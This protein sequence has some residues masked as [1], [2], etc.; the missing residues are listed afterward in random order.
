MV[1]FC[2]FLRKKRPSAGS[3]SSSSGDLGSSAKASNFLQ[4]QMRHKK[5][6]TPC[7][8]TDTSCSSS[9]DSYVVKSCLRASPQQVGQCCPSVPKQVRW[10]IS[11]KDTTAVGVS[12]IIINGES[13]SCQQQDTSELDLWWSQQELKDFKSRGCDIVSTEAA[14]HEYIVECKH[15]YT[16]VLPEIVV[17]FD[18]SN[19]A[20]A[21]PLEKAAAGRRQQR[22]LNA[23]LFTP[24]ILMGLREHAYRGLERMTAS[25]KMKARAVVKAIVEQ[26]REKNQSGAA[27]ADFARQASAADSLW[28]RAIALEDAKVAQGGL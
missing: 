3:P 6:K 25:R 14:A 4:F 7:E 11:H 2:S 20:P 27:L 17:L 22:W 12:P 15:A 28:S 19:D 13:S 1:Q 5:K 9:T 18:N 26:F 10:T 16:A 21:P 8:E 24:K 23:R